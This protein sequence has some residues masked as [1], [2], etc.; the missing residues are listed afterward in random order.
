MIIK[1]QLPKTSVSVSAILESGLPTEN[2]RLTFLAYSDEMKARVLDLIVSGKDI[3]VSSY[4]GPPR[5]GEW[6]ED[7]AQ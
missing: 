1:V 4:D 7:E 3:L 2:Q 5:D 6:F